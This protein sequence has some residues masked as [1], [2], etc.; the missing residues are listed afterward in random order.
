MAERGNRL[1]LAG[2]GP[3]TVHAAPAPRCALDVSQTKPESAP[4]Q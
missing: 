3:A 4:V 1:G 2:Q